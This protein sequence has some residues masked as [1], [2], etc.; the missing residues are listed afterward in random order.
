M[1]IKFNPDLGYQH[2]AINA[3]IGIFEGQEVRQANFS[4][5][6]IP[7]TPL[8]Q[9]ASPQDDLGIGNKLERLD[10][11]LLESVQKI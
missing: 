2:D 5:P 7:L 3:I 9:L 11:E 1:K 8:L 6:T 10:E 4:V